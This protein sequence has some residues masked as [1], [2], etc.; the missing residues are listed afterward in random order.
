MDNRNTPKARVI[1]AAELI[2][3]Q[4]AEIEVRGARVKG[5]FGGYFLAEASAD[6]RVLARSRDRNWRKAY[7]GLEIELCRQAVI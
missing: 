3:R 6:G 7:K 1:R 4:G 2:V 5:R